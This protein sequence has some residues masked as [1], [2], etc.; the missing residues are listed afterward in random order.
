MNDVLFISINDIR[1]PYLVTVHEGS[2]ALNIKHRF[3]YHSM[4]DEDYES[5][6]EYAVRVF[7][8]RATE[9]VSTFGYSGYSVEGR[10]G[11]WLKPIYG[12]HQTV[13]A[14]YD[15]YISYV[16]Y[17]EQHKMFSMFELLKKDFDTLSKLLKYSKTY[18]EF[19]TH[20]ESYL[21]L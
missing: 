21:S 20:I 15:D 18:E 7:F 14:S 2:Y 11:G 19:E 13:K 6:Y 12:K 4:P 9:L 8:N 17:V 16:E 3:T 10:N 5:A 1:N